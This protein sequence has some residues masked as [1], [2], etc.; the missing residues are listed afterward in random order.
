MWR[1]IYPAKCQLQAAPVQTK[2]N[3][4][5]CFRNTCNS[6]GKIACQ[7][8]F[9]PIDCSLHKYFAHKLVACFPAKVWHLHF[10]ADDWLQE[11]SWSSSGPGSCFNFTNTP[12]TFKLQTAKQVARARQ[13]QLQLKPNTF[14]RKTVKQILLCQAKIFDS[15]DLWRTNHIFDTFIILTFEIRSSVVAMECET[16]DDQKM[17]KIFAH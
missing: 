11:N 17:A 15:F 12:S 9:Q 1:D 10:L 7:L 13:K 8:C 3:F 16:V 14:E 6:L 5:I 2:C 4:T